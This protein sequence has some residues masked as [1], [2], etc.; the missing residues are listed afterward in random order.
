M[1][2]RS[3]SDTLLAVSPN[4]VVKIDLVKSDGNAFEDGDTYTDCTIKATDTITNQT[5]TV[6]L[7]TFTIDITP[8]AAPSTVLLSTASDTAVGGLSIDSDNIIAE[9]DITITGCAIEDTEVYAYITVDSTSV[10][11]NESTTADITSSTCTSGYDEYSLDI[12]SSYLTSSDTGKVNPTTNT[13]TVSSFD[14]AGNES[15]Q[16]SGTD[17]ILD[18][19]VDSGVLNFSDGATI[20]NVAGDDYYYISAT[21]DNSTISYTV[22]DVPLAASI[23]AD[24]ENG[25]YTY[26]NAYDATTGISDKSDGNDVYIC[27]RVTNSNGTEHYRSETSQTN[28]VFTSLHSDT[29]TPGDK[30]TNDITPD[31]LVSN[32][33][34]NAVVEIYTWDDDSSADKVVQESELTLRGVT[35]SA[36]TTATPYASSTQVLWGGTKNDYTPTINNIPRSQLFVSRY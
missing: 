5:S 4:T 28:S 29:G 6:T 17:G 32:I 8:P 27:F 26:S 25:G 3:T 1:I 30:I 14:A 23:P 24:C 35:Q 13:I 34:S 15:A 7:Q 10:R 12:L 16:S 11:T 31:I 33:E 20:Y 18:I 36:E 9:E 2:C 19:A 21:D 22:T